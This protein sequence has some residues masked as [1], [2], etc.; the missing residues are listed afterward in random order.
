MP[1]TQPP[2]CPS[3]GAED[4]RGLLP[5]KCAGGALLGVCWIVIYAAIGVVTGLRFGWRWQLLAALSF[6]PLLVLV[7]WMPRLRPWKGKWAFPAPRLRCR[8]CGEVWGWGDS[9][10]AT[11]DAE[12]TADTEA[13]Q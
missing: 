5:I 2:K 8:Q 11:P 12:E 3:C 4:V 13:D 7:I 1:A 6:L 9:P 10:A